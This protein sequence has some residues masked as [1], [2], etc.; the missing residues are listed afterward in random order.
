MRSTRK[1]VG[2]GVPLATETAELL[3]VRANVCP[4]THTRRELKEEGREMHKATPSAAL[5]L[6]FVRFVNQTDARC[7]DDTV[8]T[9][10]MGP[11][12]VRRLV[13][14]RAMS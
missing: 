3:A 9:L 8:H 10:Y 7:R 13:F 4:L 1:R 2:A 12:S 11:P 5:D 6:V 14:V